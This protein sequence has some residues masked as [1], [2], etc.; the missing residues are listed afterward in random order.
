M[1]HPY[2]RKSGGRAKAQCYAE[3]GEVVPLG[4]SLAQADRNRLKLTN[5]TTSAKQRFGQEAVDEAMKKMPSAKVL[6]SPYANRSH[7]GRLDKKA[8]K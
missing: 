3:G 2:A 8:R 4:I 6:N 1:A 7:G 5:A